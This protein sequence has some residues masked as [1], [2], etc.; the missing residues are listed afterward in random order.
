MVDMKV[1]NVKLVDCVCWMVVEVIGIGCE[2]VEVLLKQIDFEVKFVILMVFM[3]LDVVVV[4]EKF[5]VYQ[6]FLRVVLEY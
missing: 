6:G 3:G 2:E 4:R 5:V 1:I